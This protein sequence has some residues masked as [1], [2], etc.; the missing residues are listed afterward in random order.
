MKVALVWSDDLMEY[1]FGPGHPLRSERCRLGFEELRSK[2]ELDVV[3]PRYASEEELALFHTPDY[4]ES[5]RRGIAGDLDTPV[6]SRLYDPARLSV[7]ATLTAVDAVLDGYDMA[8]NLCGGW[9][10]A[11]ESRA[12]G[13]CVF[14]D[15]AVGA[16]YALK[17][18]L[19]KVMVIDWDVHHGDGTQR[20]FIRD[21]RVFTISIHQHPSTQYPYVSGYESENTETNLNIPLL[22]GETEQE[23]LKKVLPILPVKIR[24]FKPELVFVQMG[25]DGHKEDPMSSLDISDRFYTSLSKTIARCSVNNSF[26]LVFLGGGGFNFPKTAQLWREIVERAIEEIER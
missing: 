21:D 11:F 10:H 24:S 20:A 17:K 26:K 25:V 22:P 14:N 1:D 18:G 19:K 16:L 5:V 8:I 3:E 13:F 6:D 7:G 2:L 15:I 4:I 12:R 23:I 9:H